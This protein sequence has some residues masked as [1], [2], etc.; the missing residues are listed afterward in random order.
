MADANNA[1]DPSLL[2]GYPLEFWD[3]IGIR[4]LIWG[5]V[6]GVVALLLT[7]ASAYILYRVADEAQVALK[8]EQSDSNER[9]GRLSVQAEQLRKDT[10]EALKTAEQERLARIKIE[11]RLAPR[12]LTLEQRQSVIRKLKPFAGQRINFNFPPGDAEVAS[13]AETVF[14]II[15]ASGWNVAGAQV[16]D[17]VRVV[18]GILVEVEPT[19][20]ARARE[21]AEGLASALRSENLRVEGPAPINAA[22]GMRPDQAAA[23]RITI[24]AK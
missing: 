11:E 12:R 6:L 17:F 22:A 9:I 10:A 23:L 18:I 8:T 14:G 15:Q 13:I 20:D 19:A 7:A 24:G 2:W 16:Q 1:S 5:A 3:R 21:A 4:A